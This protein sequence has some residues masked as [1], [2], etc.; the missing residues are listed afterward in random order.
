VFA[1]IAEG[2]RPGG[3]NPIPNPSPFYVK[4]FQPDRA[5]SYELGVK[6][7][8]ADHRLRA[9]AT[10]YY[11]DW[12][13]LQILGEPADPTLGFT[14]NA[15]RAHSQGF[16]AEFAALPIQGLEFDLGVGYADPRIDTPAEGA[17][18]G[19]VLPGVSRFNMAASA[20]YEWP[21]ND[22]WRGVARADAWMHSHTD[23]APQAAGLNL[24]LG[25]ENDR[26]AL[27]GFIRNATNNLQITVTGAEG[28]FIGQPRTYGVDLR[29]RF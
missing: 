20:Q 17:P 8:T 10:I 2:Y 19:T 3:V 25:A 26:W 23:S 13:N 28:Q 15:G 21:L 24:R 7:E 9:N 1:N 12:R 5:W 29:R 16:E 4:T 18:P 11:I 6:S 22:K 14:T 27:Y